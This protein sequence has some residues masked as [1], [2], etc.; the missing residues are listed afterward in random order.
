VEAFHCAVD[1]LYIEIGAEETKKLM[2]AW[3]RQ[4]CSDLVYAGYLGFQASLSNFRNPVASQFTKEDYEIFLREHIMKTMPYRRE[5]E[6]VAAEIQ[7]R[8]KDALVKQED[9]ILNY[10]IYLEMSGPKL[11][12]FYGYRFANQFLSWVE[13]G[14]VCD[15]F[16]TSVYAMVLSQ[17]LGFNC[18]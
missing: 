3:N 11:A 15:R 6:H 9:P 13:P 1:N 12:H 4:I 17:E 7:E 16:Q 2:T 8:H 10:Y 5:A 14:Y 18:I